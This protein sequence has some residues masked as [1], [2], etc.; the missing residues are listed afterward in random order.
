MSDRQ[1]FRESSLENINTHDDLDELLQVNSIPTWLWLAAIFFMITGFLLWVFMGSISERVTGHGQ[2]ITMDKPDKV[3][4][5]EA[6]IVDTIFYK[7]GDLVLPGQTLLNI[8][9][10]DKDT[11]LSMISRSGG[12]IIEISVREGDY[13]EKG[14]MIMQV[15]NNLEKPAFSPGI[16]FFVNESDVLK[17]QP[18]M[19]AE[20]QINSPELPYS[21]RKA[22]VVSISKYRTAPELV[23]KYTGLIDSD[24]K[25]ESGN[26]YEV[27][28]NLN[29]NVK[30]MTDSEKMMIRSMN[31]I[32]CKISV[33]VSTESPALFFLHRKR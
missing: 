18:G 22:T 9:I 19:L 32:Y 28:A 25:M 12:E 7:T 33:V 15:A 6:G 4:A 16:V 1:I 29:V 13:I 30:N 8:Y 17:L 10:P 11:S 31:G 2:I 5:S 26:F 23:K 14:A 27:R 3:F 21:F 20:L 24:R